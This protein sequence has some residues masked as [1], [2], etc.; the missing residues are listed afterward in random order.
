MRAVVC[1]GSRAAWEALRQRLGAGGGPWSA[2]HAEA[3]GRVDATRW[4]FDPSS[5]EHCTRFFDEAYAKGP[6]RRIVYMAGLDVPDGLAREKLELGASLCG[7]GPLHL[8]Q[9]MASTEWERFPRLFL[10]T[11]GAQPPVTSPV[12]ALLWGLGASFAELPRLETTLLDL[13]DAAT[14]DDVLAEPSTRIER[15][16]RALPGERRVPATPE[17]HR[18]APVAPRT[19]VAGSADS[20]TSQHVV[21]PARRG[22]LGMGARKLLTGPVDPPLERKP[23]IEGPS[24]RRDGSLRRRPDAEAMARCPRIGAGGGRGAAGRADLKKASE[25]TR[26]VA[27]VFG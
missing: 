14:A 24:A 9:S 27:T 19:R 2:S 10:V 17:R 5:R 6:P 13:D 26:A 15:S 16:R 7:E 22:L 8:V 23:R 3:Y 25:V 4:T 20:V 11:R 12:Q 18:H 1:S 21:E